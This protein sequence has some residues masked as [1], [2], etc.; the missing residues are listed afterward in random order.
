MRS[1]IW[2]GFVAAGSLFA[3]TPGCSSDCTFDHTCPYDGGDGSAG[4]GTFDAPKDCDTAKDPKDS[5]ACVVDTVGVFVSAM[6]SDAAPGTKAM[7]VQT[8]GKGFDLA[9]MK[10]LPRVYVCAGTYGALAVDDKRDGVSAFG[11]FDCAGWMPGSAPTLVRSNDNKPSLTATN[12]TAGISLVDLQFQSQDASVPGD[13]SIAVLAANATLTMR[14][15]KV[16]AGKGASA[17]KVADPIDFSPASQPAGDNGKMNGAGNQTPNNCAN[18]SGNSI[19]GSGGGPGGVDGANGQPFGMYP[20]NPALSD[21]KGGNHL[22]TCG[23]GATGFDG[24]YG[25][26][27]A[28]GGAGAA[29]LGAIDAMGWHPEAGAA[30]SQGKVGQGGGG[31]ASKDNQGGGGGGGPGGCGGDGGKGG[32]GGGASI[33]I[34]S[35]QSTLTLEQT[36]LVTKNAGDGAQGQTGQKAQGGGLP[37][38]FFMTSCNGGAGGHGGS[39]AGGGGGAGGVS[40]GIAYTGTAPKIDG[41]SVMDA[42]TRPSVMLGQ[43]GMPGAAGQGGPAF[44]ITNPVSNAGANG[45]AGIVGIAQAVKAF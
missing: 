40:V 4:D 38:S 35:F 21:G 12:L 42:M 36:T 6:G 17:T 2:I 32:P 14:R 28:T 41:E 26:G 13:S 37:G 27:G 45:T 15:A 24:S 34:A 7:P 10:G 39:G 20:V 16:E 3:S 33:A 8:V 11:G 19:G 25:P 44:K 30:G 29:K 31:G 23:T 18:G 43:P 22:L 1:S 9:K 5:P